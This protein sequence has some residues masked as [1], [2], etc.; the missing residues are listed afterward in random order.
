MA[1]HFYH[2]PLHNALGF[3]K[4][5]KSQLNQLTQ[6]KKQ[7]EYNK[8]LGKSYYLLQLETFVSFFKIDKDLDYALKTMEY[9]NSVLFLDTLSKSMNF[10]QFKLLENQVQNKDFFYAFCYLYAQQSPEAFVHFMQKTFIHYH[11]AFNQNTTTKIDHKEMCQT[12]LKSK[13]MTVKE[14]FGENEKGS[15]FKILMDDKVIISEKG[16]VIKTLRKKVYKN[17]FYYLLD[18]DEKNCSEQN[19]K[20]F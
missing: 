2:I 12:L 11:T 17:L 14:S 1:K 9:F 5:H 18:L 19:F 13:K 8:L 10:S 6:N 3:I 16:K 4:A 7:L 20:F 15:F